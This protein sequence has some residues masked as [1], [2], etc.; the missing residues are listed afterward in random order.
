MTH[1]VA[2]HNCSS[3]PMEAKEHDQKYEIGVYFASWSIYSRQYFPENVPIHAVNKIYYAFFKVDSDGVVSEGDLWADSQIWRDWSDPHAGEKVWGCIGKFNELKNKRKF[4][5]ICSIGGWNGSHNFSQVAMSA[6]KREIF[7]NS[8]K[9]LT[10]RYKFDGFDIDWEYPGAPGAVLNTHDSSDPQNLILLLEEMREKLGKSISISIC[11]GIGKPKYQ[12]L[13]YKKL[14]D[15]LDSYTIMA[16]DI[17]G[18]WSNVAGHHAPL[19]YITKSLL[20]LQNNYGINLSKV[21]L[22]LPLY[23][24]VF[25]GCKDVGE[26]YNPQRLEKRS[27]QF[28]AG[29]WDYKYIPNKVE[30]YF[31]SAERA[32]YGVIAG[33]C[34]ISFD[35][36][37]VVQMKCEEV[38]RLG[39][40][41]VFFWE[42][43]GDKSTPEESLIEIAAN[44]LS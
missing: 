6:T 24:R 14:N 43:S 38:R 40:K 32:S 29:I 42:A 17:S 20:D 19:S 10:S 25:D 4:Q 37:S 41:G 13:D 12:L 3:P 22:G 30:I 1:T 18:P 7:V 28:E 8:I 9:K 23:G 11:V 44:T 34:L 33:D 26:N 16:F 21:N 15:I 39:L 35:T 5:L 2:M 27:D 31:D 36:P